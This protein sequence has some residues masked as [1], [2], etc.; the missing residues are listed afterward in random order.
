MLC[1]FFKEDSQFINIFNKIIDSKLFMFF[2]VVLGLF[3]NLFSIELIVY[4]IYA[5]IVCLVSIFGKNFIVNLPMAVVGYMTFSKENNPRGPNNT[6]IFFEKEVQIYFIIICVFIGIFTLSRMIHDLV[7]YKERRKTPRLGLGFLILGI[8][9]I[10]GGVF[11]DGYEFKSSLF[12]LLEIIALS[13]SYFIFYYTSDF[14]RIDK[15]Y[16]AELFTIVSIMMF[17]EVGYVLIE[18]G[19]FNLNTPLNRSELWT[20]WGH[21]NNMGGIVLMCMPAPFYLATVKKHGWIYCL[22]GNFA[23]LS[24]FLCMSRNAMLVGTIIY[25]TMFI[26]V[27]K[28]SK[29]ENRVNNLLVYLSC[30]IIIAI[31]ITF[32]N[33][34]VYNL[35]YETISK[36]FSFSGRIEI[37][38]HAI[39]E[40]ISSPIFG[41]DFYN[42]NIGQWGEYSPNSFLPG[43]YHNTIFQLLASTGIVGLLAYIY[44]RYETIKLLFKNFNYSKLFIW[45]S[46]F[47][48]LVS[49]LFD[50][51]FFN[52]GPG[53]LYSALLLLLEKQDELESA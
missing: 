16:W 1:K 3:S 5:L 51:F 52:F 35:L 10:I 29:E 24:C 37:Y 27:L 2:I 34:V 36:G 28:K 4:T 45:L 25:I 33:D 8:S 12:G 46:I 39:E 9:F 23:T 40:F 19:V 48:F 44:H 21:H 32:Y 49:S 15:E 6:S 50:C 43:R 20:G 38:S 47:A 26:L 17:I 18:G 42:S 41:K 30:F 31:S 53:L 7:S 13:F 11:S 14:K 22:L